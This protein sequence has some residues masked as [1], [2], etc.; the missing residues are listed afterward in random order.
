MEIILPYNY[1]PRDYQLSLLKALDSGYKRA[2]W[3]AHRRAGKDKTG[4]NYTIKRM[5]ERV[6]IYY[7]FLPT[8]NQGRKIIWD[9]IDKDGF[10]FLNHFPKELIEKKNEAEMKILM[11]GGSLFQIIGT[12]KIDAIMGT[13]PVGC[14]FS[15]FA[16]QNPLAWE[17]VRPI[18][19]ENGGWALFLYTPRG[20][21]HGF[22][23]YEM[24]RDNDEWFCELLTVK[25][26]GVI[27]EEEI[28]KE[29]AEGMDEDLIQQEYYCSFEGMMMGAYY[30]KQLK[31]AREDNRI[32]NVPYKPQIQVD[33]W[34][35]LGVGDATAIWFTQAVGREIRVIDY[36]EN[37]G[38]GLLHYAKV[39]QE[40]PYVY[41]THN[42][43][44]DIKQRELGTGKSRLETA[45]TMGIDFRI[46]PQLPIEDGIE[47]ARNIFNQCWFDKERCKRGIDALKNY[48]KEYDDDRKE[49]KNRPYHDW[50]SHGADGFR[51]FAIGFRQEYPKQLLL[52][53]EEKAFYKMKQKQKI[54]KGQDYHLKMA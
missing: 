23:L 21:N 33:T 37:S 32:V 50:S 14:V 47:A 3:V 53:P 7:Y 1:K 34:W 19:R 46:V 52:T 24:A 26:T 8:Y 51:Y 4:L 13:N 12:D 11:K 28:D 25:D 18:L 44:F 42:A 30:S 39:L 17:Y 48:H 20:H 22:D 15:E 35:D 54:K 38:E 49:F 43:P 16:L 9:G 2:V 36:Y 29:R 40:K 10:K 27:S 5:P 41:R 45:K 31:Q 6:G